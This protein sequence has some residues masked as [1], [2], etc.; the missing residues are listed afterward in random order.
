MRLTE[1][2]VTRVGVSVDP[3]PGLDLAFDFALQQSTV[4]SRGQRSTTMT[5][6]RTGALVAAIALALLGTLGL[7]AYVHSAKDR[8][9]AGDKMVDVYVA[10]AK[11]TAGTPADQLHSKVKLVKVPAKVRASGAVTDLASIKGEVA[12]I[13]IASGE[14]L[15]AAR[16]VSADK[17]ASQVQSSTAVPAGFFQSTVSLDPDQALGGQVRAGNRVAVVAI[18]TKTDSTQTAP[19]TAK[20]IARNVLVTTVQID[21]TKGQSADQNPQLGTAPT[22]KFLV[23]LA[24]TQTDLEALV[25]AV[26]NGTI[27]LAAE[28]I[29]K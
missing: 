17:Q 19:Q 21:G 8:A 25:T 12:E 2:R 29:A 1:D 7:T 22:G 20:V 6:Q 3:N 4:R 27:S 5:F 11:I 23:T 10:S 28:A 9:T 13:D 24:V 18:D 16:W 26:N 14:E 15:L